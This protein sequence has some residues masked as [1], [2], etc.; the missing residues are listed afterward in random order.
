LYI[1]I[2]VEE[3]DLASG[4]SVQWQDSRSSLKH[5]SMAYDGIPYMVA[6]FQILACQYGDSKDAA[7]K[8]KYVQRK[9][10]LIHRYVYNLT[11]C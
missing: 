7:R 11:T 2:I 4:H 8:L 6:S 5:T 10:Y 3:I 9:V 1:L